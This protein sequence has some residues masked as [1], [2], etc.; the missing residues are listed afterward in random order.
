MKKKIKPLYESEEKRLSLDERMAHADKYINF[1]FNDGDSK[2]LYIPFVEEL[3]KN[4]Q[5]VDIDIFSDIATY[6]EKQ[7]IKHKQQMENLDGD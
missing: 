1:I 7:L 5:L 6:L 2:P 4:E 3:K